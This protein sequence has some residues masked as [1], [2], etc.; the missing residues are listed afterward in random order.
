[1][2]KESDGTHFAAWIRLVSLHDLSGNQSGLRLGSSG[3]FVRLVELV[4]HGE[5]ALSCCL[6]GYSKSE[7][8]QKQ[9]VAY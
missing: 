8:G 7:F 6:R 2:E 1:M 4:A 9:S 3:F 5:V